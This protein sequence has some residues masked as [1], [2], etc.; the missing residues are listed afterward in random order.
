M[1]PRL[2]TSPRAGDLGRVLHRPGMTTSPRTMG[3][4]SSEGTVTG[5]PTT[6]PKDARIPT[7]TK[8]T[9]FEDSNRSQSI[10]IDHV[11]ANQNSLQLSG[12]PTAESKAAIPYSNT[13]K[14]TPHNIEQ[15]PP[16][17][18]VQDMIGILEDISA[19][20]NPPSEQSTDTKVTDLLMTKH[21]A[22][23]TVADIDNAFQGAAGLPRATARWRPSEST[24]TRNHNR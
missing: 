23:T 24:P 22:K 14:N 2:T 11:V 16:P 3:P 1:V 12:N 15:P 7:R 18:E 8:Q 9:P 13:T 6:G 17:S 5:R 4:L 19:L 20:L 10:S 21:I